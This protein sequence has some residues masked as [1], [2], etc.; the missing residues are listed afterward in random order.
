MTLKLIRIDRLKR[1]AKERGI[2]GPVQLGAAIGRKTNQTSDL[3][4]GR[5]SF[6][7]KVARSIE[8][9]AGLPSGWLDQDEGDRVGRAVARLKDAVR[10]EGT[11][12][13]IPLLATPGS[14]GIGSDVMPEEVVVGRLSLS[15]HWIEKTI[16]S[17]TRPEHLRFIH[18]YGDSMQPTFLDGDVLL[19]DSGVNQVKIDGVY[20]LEANDRIY[21]KRVRQRMDGGF[22]ISSDNPNVKTVDV[23]DGNTPVNVL[24]RVVFLWNGR[25]L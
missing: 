1:F 3:L 23:L 24:G 7:E 11:D 8:E 19:V 6:G 18:G 12:V 4:S 5:A 22:E 25:R 21:I 20:V 14:M 15:P 2:D 17:S 13:E 10:Q 16:S 9:A